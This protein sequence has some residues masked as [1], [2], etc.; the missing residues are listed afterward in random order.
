MKSIFA[1]ASAITLLA[2][3]ASASLAQP[4]A[5][6]P[7]TGVFKTGQQVYDM[8]VSNKA[9][10]IT[11]CDWFIMAGHDMMKFYGDIGM[12]GDKI[13]VPQG[14][15]SAALRQTLVDFWKEAPARRTS[16]ASSAIYIALRDK[17]PCT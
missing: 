15:T 16:S 5:T 2:A 17:Y 12:G 3:S 8:C 10:D 9:E 13:C 7:S 11:A 1:A 6:T 14:T 4:P